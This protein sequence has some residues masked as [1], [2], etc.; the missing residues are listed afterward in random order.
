M[1]GGTTVVYPSSVDGHLGCFHF[2]AVMNHAA[3]N[4]R[5]Q[6]SMWTHGFVFLGQTPRSG[7]AGSDSNSIF[8][9]WRN[10]QTVFHSGCPFSYSHQPRR[11]VLISLPKCSLQPFNVAYG[12]C[13]SRFPSNAT[14]PCILECISPALFT[15]WGPLPTSEPSWASH[16]SAA[17][18]RAP[19]C[20]LSPPGSQNPH[21]RFQ[22][23]CQ[24]AVI[25]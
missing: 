18:V 3:M 14:L 11:R 1:C 22:S 20:P 12:S 6:V 15:P 13:S 24:R 2:G 17:S 7:I 5:V 9:L 21:Q 4:I 19:G 10:R 23:G 8:N 25:V 16:C